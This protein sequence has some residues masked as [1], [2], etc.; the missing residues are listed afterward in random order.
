MSLNMN[1]DAWPCT[2]MHL[3]DNGCCKLRLNSKFRK[4]LNKNTQL[5]STVFTRDTNTKQSD[6][7]TKKKIPFLVQCLRIDLLIMVLY[8]FMHHYYY[9][10]FFC[11]RQRKACSVKL[12]HYKLYQHFRHQVIF[13]QTPLGADLIFSILLVGVN[14]IFA[15]LPPGA[16]LFFEPGKRRDPS[17]AFM[18]VTK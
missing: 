8:K 17:Q 10:C 11:T 18:P 14:L 5:S 7:H 15:N 16:D 9:H 2:S 1:L 13:C 4:L 3:A 12:I 6:D